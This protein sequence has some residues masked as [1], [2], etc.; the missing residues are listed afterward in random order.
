MLSRHRSI[1]LSHSCV[2][3]LSFHHALVLHIPD[4]TSRHRR[5]D[6]PFKRLPVLAEIIGR[7]L[8]QRIGSIRLEEEELRRQSQRTPDHQSQTN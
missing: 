7:F 1:D 8:I 3:R 6:I 2:S 5:A 4:G